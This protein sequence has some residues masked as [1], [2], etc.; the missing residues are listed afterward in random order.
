MACSSSTCQVPV[1]QLQ[2]KGIALTSVYE[3]SNPAL[4]DFLGD[5][6]RRMILLAFVRQERSLTEAS[7]SLVMPLNLLH[8]HVKRLVGLGAL[9]VVREQRR[10]GRAIRYYRASASA[11]LIPS[12]L[13]TKSV[14]ASLSREL[15]ALLDD[16]AGEAAGMMLDLDEADRPRLRFVGDELTAIPWETWRV[17]RLSTGETAKFASELK[18]LVKR[19]EGRSRA[20]GPTF[21]FHAAIVR[22]RE[23]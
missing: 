19:Y 18:E 1:A 6:R 3:V 14:G 13:M 10:G 12:H 5:T 11:F 23:G 22:R 20:S 17:M 9:S 21:L 4:A 16:A 7:A 2:L 8:Y 15:R